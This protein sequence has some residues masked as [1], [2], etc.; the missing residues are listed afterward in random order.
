MEIDVVYDSSVT[1]APE[2]FQ[3]AINTAVQY[4]DNEFTNPATITIEVGYGE[5]P[6]P[7][8]GPLGSGD[9]GESDWAP[10]G[11]GTPETYSA[12]RSALLAEGAPG[13][14]TL[15]L[16]SPFGSNQLYISPAE[17]LALGLPISATLPTVSGST[18]DAY[19]GFSSVPDIFDYSSGGT[20]SADEYYLIGVIE[21]EFT[22]DMGRVSLLSFPP[23]GQYS[24]ADL[25]R[26]SSPGVLDLTTGRAGSTAYF[27]INDGNT[28]LGNWN[29][30]PNNGDLADWYPEG[31]APGGDDAFNDYSNS[32]VVNI[33]STDDIILMA[34]LGWT[35]GVLVTSANSPYYVSS[36]VADSDNIIIGSGS[37]V[38]LSG[39][40]A[41]T[42]AINSGGFLVIE[43]GGIE[44]GASLASG[45]SEIVSTGGVDVGAQVNGGVQDL[46]GYASGATVFSGLQLAASGGTA[47]DT[48]IS[49]GGTLTVVAGG[50]ADPATIF[51]GGNE[52]LS[53]GGN[54]LDAQISGGVQTVFGNVS[55]AIIFTG[56]QTVEPGGTANGTVVSGGAQEV[57]GT[58]HGTTVSGGSQVVA[59][60]G[61]ASGTILSGSGTQTVESGGSVSD[62]MFG[63]GVQNVLSG[64]SVS[65]AD[66][67]SGSQNVS[68]GGT[69]LAAVVDGAGMQN[70]LGG[71]TASGTTLSGGSEIVSVHGTDLDAQISGGTQFVFGVA[72][73]AT[74]F[75]GGSQT[76][77]SGGTTSGSIVS[78]GT[79][80][81]FSAGTASGTIVAGGTET[82][83]SGGKDL[84]AQISGGTEFDYG[85]ISGATVFGGSQV[86]ESGGTGADSI[87]VTGGSE[88]ISAH[89]SE[90]AAQISGGTDDVYG[91]ASGAT[92]FSSGY[93]VV[94]SGGTA[95]GATILG[96]GTQ[97]LHGGLASG[98]K[99]S[100]GGVQEISSGAVATVTN[101]TIF[102]GGTQY[103]HAGSASSTTI[104]GG[105]QV[106]NSSGTLAVG[107]T[108]DDGGVQQLSFFASAV[109][110]TLTSGGL[111]YILTAGT[112]S[113]TTVSSGGRQ[114][115]APSAFAFGTVVNG[116]QQNLL[117]GIAN[118][119]TINAFGLQEVSSGSAASGSG[120]IYAFGTAIATNVDSGGEQF[121]D[122]GGSAIGATVA[123]GGTQVVGADGAV[124]GTIVKAGGTEVL[125]SGGTLS[126]VTIS[127]GGTLELVGGTAST[128]PMTLPPG[129]ILAAGPGEVFSGF[130]V[131]S[132]MKV[133][134]LSGG[135][136]DGGTILSGGTLM[137]SS[138]GI[139]TGTMV[140]KGGTEII[141]SG[142]SGISAIIASG[143]TEI[144]ASDGA[145]SVAGATGGVMLASGSNADIILESVTI[146]GGVLETSADGQIDVYDSGNLFRDVAIRGSVSIESS[147]TL[148]FISGILSAGAIL[149][150]A[151]GGT[152]VV[153]GTVTNGGTLYA[154]ASHS[155]VEIASGAVVDGGIAEVGNGI[156]EIR[157]PSSEE[158]NFLATGSG[159]LELADAKA[160]AGDVI[161][162][163][164]ASHTDHSQFIDL[165]AVTYSAALVRES[166]RKRKKHG[167]LTVTSGG[168]VVATIDM[169]GKYAASDF[170]LT[171]GSGGSGTI[172]T[173]PAVGGGGRVETGFG[174]TNDIDQASIALGANLTLAYLEHSNVTGGALI[175]AYNRDA[176]SIALLGNYM[177]TSFV[178]TADAHGAFLTS[179]ASQ[180]ANLQPLLSHPRS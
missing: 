81:L 71:G 147:G 69:A 16:T 102:G 122:S 108:I 177:A 25:Y 170:R 124:S 24:I 41:T 114:N 105:T 50:L 93:Q 68:S 113:N 62:T 12:V 52:I 153:S 131:S 139:D 155:L 44:G 165:T 109:S 31:P 171:S 11:Q 180:T 27:S 141:S 40:T 83:S 35:T 58:A 75:S 36:G 48:T 51:S 73:G 53:A 61:T 45:G 91:Y 118:G 3:T 144:A 4:L 6:G 30:N 179:E 175:V 33:V 43:S 79:L 142:G 84:A 98:T 158:V 104:S 110:T 39:G 87:V 28:N 88:I 100:N 112:A 97:E 137:V 133:A 129:A 178:T 47:V 64:A 128:S 140:S 22:E 159:G 54:D 59:A 152:A 95:T 116:G 101:T 92:M 176:A 123:S 8:G 80:D 154:S 89:G 96:G 72:S 37:M 78:G 117:G 65:G 145:T 86:V 77:E 157:G 9:L 56:S 174:A 19:A 162:F 167:V 121:V 34:A 119:T 148:I 94:E 74:I 143:G 67:V 115:I 161:G 111:Q 132:G 2:Q 46:Y 29:N 168:A 106:V 66:I 42:T 127:S 32:G 63:G 125:E 13:A 38:V 60:S 17:A 150:T 126:A 7:D 85:V 49:S 107:T 76:I 14:S 160:Y 55:G 156:V 18:I 135:S 82:V 169:V 70:V 130:T 146:S 149:E 166:Y 15:P 21:H 163:G 103:V 5:L 151:S 138:D 23:S 90:F 164:G 26:Y 20:V 1:S 136:D 173:D 134:V 120:F 172:I 99:I 57:S 10:D